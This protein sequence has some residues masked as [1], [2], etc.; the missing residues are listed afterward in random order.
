MPR[1]NESLCV[2]A[3][4]IMISLATLSLIKRVDGNLNHS[5]SSILFPYGQ[6]S[7]KG[8]QNPRK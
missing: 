6:I 7:S 5:F 2:S 8:P 4:D 3:Y 1:K